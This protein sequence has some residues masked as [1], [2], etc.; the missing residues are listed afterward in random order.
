MVIQQ[1]F[2]IFSWRCRENWCFKKYNVCELDFQ[3]NSQSAIY[4][5]FPLF[6]T[7]GKLH[8]AF[9]AQKDSN[10]LYGHSS[11]ASLQSLQ[12]ICL[13]V[14][15]LLS[16]AAE[17]PEWPNRSWCSYLH[18]VRASVDQMYWEPC[19]DPKGHVV[20]LWAFSEV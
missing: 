1:Y 11:Q 12:S 14:R 2:A 10:I 9:L 17:P 20:K 5:V 13:P 3:S 18:I 6:L 8:L 15:T 4:L 19:W 16:V 7:T